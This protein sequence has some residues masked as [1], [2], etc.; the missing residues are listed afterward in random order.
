[1]LIYI[2]TSALAKWYLNE[3]QSEAFSAWVQNQPDTHISSL[4]TLEFRCLLSRRRRQ[5]DI[6]ADLEQQLF[7][8]HKADAESGHLTR[9][10]VDNADHVS[11][12]TLLERVSP[13]ALRALDAIHLSIAQRIG[14]ATLATADVTMAS[15]AGKLGIQV[16]DFGN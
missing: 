5:H 10:D 4:T 15:A 8:A 13:T 11:A 12:I 16:I 14:A 6:S 1:M 9:H 7:A 2:D 3:A